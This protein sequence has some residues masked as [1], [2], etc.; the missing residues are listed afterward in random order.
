MEKTIMRSFITCTLHN[1]ERRKMHIIFW[2]ANFKGWNYLECIGVRRDFR[3]IRCECVE[4]DS[5]G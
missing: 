5:S 1:M 3:K 4:V 2:S